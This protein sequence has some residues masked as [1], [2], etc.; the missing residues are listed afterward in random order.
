MDAKKTGA[1]IALLRHEKNLTQQELGEKLI[2]HTDNF[3]L[4]EKCLF[5]KQKWKREH[6]VQRILSLMIIMA[7]AILGLVYSN[8]FLFIPALLAL[9]GTHLFFYN[10][11]MAYVEQHAFDGSG[12]QT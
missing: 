3:S 7:V 1:F 6:E 9:I 8:M 5:F 4:E 2:L 10:R 11:M 12:K